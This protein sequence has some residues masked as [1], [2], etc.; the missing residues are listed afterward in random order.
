MYCERLM[1]LEWVYG[2]FRDNHYT[3]EGRSVHDRADSPGGRLP[4]LPAAGEPSDQAESEET[5]VEEKPYQA[6]AIWLTSDVLGITAKIDIVEGHDDGRVIPIEY[7]RGKVP[8]VPERA[9]LPERVQ[10]CAQVLLLREHGYMCEQAEI[11]FAASK[12]RVS[13]DI[14]DDLI[15][16]TRWTVGV[17][18]EVAS[19]ADPPPPLRDSPKCRGCSLAEICLP[20]E[21][22]LLRRLDDKRIVEPPDLDEELEASPDP[23]PWGLASHEPRDERASRTR[24]LYPARDD[25]VPLYVHGHGAQI[26]LAGERLAVRGELHTTHVRLMNTAQVVVRGNVQ[27]STQAARALLDRG[28]PLV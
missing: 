11:Y 19:A 4:P 9:Y 14:G 24:R 13:I 16:H 6:R 28:I 1:Y 15:E 8:N 5:E 27:V 3:V 21:V 12:Q 2:E 7:K 20:D 26:G 25:R 17:A 10:L 23:D 18:R 22:N